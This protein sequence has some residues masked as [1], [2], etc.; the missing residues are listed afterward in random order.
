MMETTQIQLSFDPVLE[1]LQTPIAKDL[2][3]N[4]RRILEEGTLS[5]EEAY[6]AALSLAHS[7]EYAALKDF[8]IT[9]LKE[10]GVAADHI[11]EAI[12]CAAMMAMLNTYYRFRHMVGKEEEYRVAGLRMTGLSRPVMGKER[13]EMLAFTLSVLNGCESC[14]RSHEQVLRL[15]GLTG[16]KIH[17]L[18]RLASVVRALKVL[19]QF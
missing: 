5:K 19:S 9:Q 17:D 7:V 15:A 4:L 12:E 1:A 10:I 18:A 16:D 11:Q 14:I 2:R 8:A 13:F 3:L 6:L